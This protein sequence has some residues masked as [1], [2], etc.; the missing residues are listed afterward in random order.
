MAY[1]NPPTSVDPISESREEKSNALFALGTV[2]ANVALIIGGIYWL[3]KRSA[4][5]LEK[6]N[7]TDKKRILIGTILVIIYMIIALFWFIKDALYY[8]E[9]MT[10]LSNSNALIMMWIPIGLIVIGGFFVGLAG[11]KSTV[12]M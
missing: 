2:A 10:Q 11:S 4:T 8:K 12:Y 6:M 3:V 1:T 9:S 7:S 5:D